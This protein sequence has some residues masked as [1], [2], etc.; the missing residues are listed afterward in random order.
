MKKIILCISDYYYPAMRGGGVP[1]AL[2]T[3]MTWLKA[4]Y[5]FQVITHDFDVG[6][7]QPMPTITH[8]TWS[9]MDDI[10]VR[11]LSSEESL[12]DI[13]HQTP[14]NMVYLNSLFGMFAVQLIIGRL[15]RRIPR[16]TLMI[17]PH[18]ELYAGAL[19]Q[20][21]LKKRLFL[22]VMKAFGAYK[23]IL[24]HAT[25]DEE[26]EQIIKH[27]GANRD[28]IRIAPVLPAPITHLPKPT[29]KQSG[30]LKIIFLSRITPKKNLDGALKL[31]AHV[32]HPVQFDIYGT[33]E[34]SAYWQYCESLMRN[35]P[36][37]IQ[38]RYCGAITEGQTELFSQYHLFLFPT[39]GENFGYVIQESLLGGCL[40]L[41]STNTPWRRLA[42]KQVGWDV[43][44]EES[45]LNAL[46]QAVMMDNLTFQMWANNAQQYG[47]SIVNDPVRVA[48]NRE[49][50]R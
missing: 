10:P 9:T 39:H 20:K 31:L 8:G 44:S 38:A 46:E 18:G 33:Q 24:W 6:A 43:S 7:T 47:L 40:P 41:I 3:M 36:R 50:F 17:A 48:Q 22:M 19:A 5:Q 13:I 15:T 11:Y 32:K 14:Y 27:I 49:L 30:E 16:T 25:T 34:D 45:Y 2:K 37:H 28:M 1:H 21:H 42:D 23:Q 35:L 26:A 12:A 4:D 29:S